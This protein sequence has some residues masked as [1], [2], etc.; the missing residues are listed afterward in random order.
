VVDQQSIG[1]G[2]KVVSCDAREGQLI[3]RDVFFIFVG[4]SGLALC[5]VGLIKLAGVIERKFEK[6][7]Y[8]NMWGSPKFHPRRNSE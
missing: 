5:V 2:T 1:V 3:A 8:L 6:P 7:E 4:A